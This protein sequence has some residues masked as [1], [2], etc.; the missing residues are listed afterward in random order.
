MPLNDGL[1]HPTVI[2]AMLAPALLMAATGSLLISANARLARV[3]DR[4]RLLVLGE[5]EPHGEAPPLAE[6]QRQ[7]HEH[8]RRAAL[9]LRACW[10]LYLAL[11]C[12]IGTS[13]ALAATA[14]VDPRLGLLATALALI[15]M[16][17]LLGAALAMGREVS[18]AV[19]S[20]DAELDTA[21]ARRRPGGR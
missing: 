9:V 18:L 15:G 10:M 14:L 5:G 20:L 1:A 6:N 21:L 4:L 8:R 13:L 11:G 2:S 19:H 12:F 17:G 7:I 3:V 16:G